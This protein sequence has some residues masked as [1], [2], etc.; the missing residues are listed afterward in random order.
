MKNNKSNFAIIGIKNVFS[1]M[2][3]FTNLSVRRSDHLPYIFFSKCIDAFF[4]VIKKL[5]CTS[6]YIFNSEKSVA[7]KITINNLESG[8]TNIGSVSRNLLSRI[9]IHAHSFG[10]I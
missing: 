10:E 2:Q 5:Q 9:E 7:L 3:H 6:K 1:I 4:N 8:T